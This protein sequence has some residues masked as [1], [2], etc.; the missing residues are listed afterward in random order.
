MYFGNHYNMLCYSVTS[1]LLSPCHGVPERV[2]DTS[3]V[4]APS[5]Y[6]QSPV[7]ERGPVITA[8]WRRVGHSSDSGGSSGD[9][10]DSSATSTDS[11]GDPPRVSVHTTPVIV[12]S[13]VISNVDYVSQDCEHGKYPWRSGSKSAMEHDDDSSSEE[14]KC[15]IEQYDEQSMS[16]TEVIKAQRHILQGNRVSYPWRTHYHDSDSDVSLSSL[17][18]TNMAAIF[19]SPTSHHGTEE[20]MKTINVAKTI[21]LHESLVSAL[22]LDGVAAPNTMEQLAMQQYPYVGYSPKELAESL[23]ISAIKSGL[24]NFNSTDPNMDIDLRGVPIENVQEMVEDLDRR[25]DRVAAQ[26]PALAHTQRHMNSKAIPVRS[27]E[28]YVA[29][30]NHENT[31]IFV[32]GPLISNET[33]YINTSQPMSA[34]AL[35]AIKQRLF[36]NPPLEEKTH[37][38]IYDL[39]SPITSPL[40]QPITQSEIISPRLHRKVHFAD[41]VEHSVI[42]I[43]PNWSR[44][45]LHRQE[46]RGIAADVFSVTAA[47]SEFQP[48]LTS[49]VITTMTLPDTKTSI[50]I[51]PIQTSPPLESHSVKHAIQLRSQSASSKITLVPTVPPIRPPV[52]KAHIMRTLSPTYSNAPSAQLANRV[53]VPPTLTRITYSPMYSDNLK[54][55]VL[56]SNLASQRRNSSPSNP[57]TRFIS[58]CRMI[59]SSTA[60]KYLGYSLPIPKMSPEL[61]FANRPQQGASPNIN[62]SIMHKRAD[63]IIPQRFE[64]MQREQPLSVQNMD[65]PSVA[66]TYSTPPTYEESM[67]NK[68]RQLLSEDAPSSVVGTPPPVQLR[69]LSPVYMNNFMDTLNSSQNVSLTSRNPPSPVYFTKPIATENQPAFAS[70]SLMSGTNSPV[71]IRD[72]S[73]PVPLTSM[74]YAPQSRPQGYIRQIS[75]HVTPVPTMIVPQHFPFPRQTTSPLANTAVNT[76]HHSI[77]QGNTRTKPTNINF[78]D[79]C[80]C[81]D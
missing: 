20:S 74:P 57:V 31:E 69:Q 3:I 46:Q 17:S 28:M 61:N 42:E 54:N 62:V 72:V 35:A 23:Q 71:V 44:R 36:G 52:Q 76:K 34:E 33:I 15:P 41:P 27:D 13:V 21:P 18:D 6:V 40:M 39:T 53:N 1:G 56:I 48:V 79:L 49:P 37:Q 50:V 26:E 2:G 51:S 55:N 78:I 14:K 80:L 60:S 70:P 64:I 29:T 9:S 24:D 58:P 25:L 38:R 81:L 10:S 67:R 5:S 68:S 77:A 32:D 65:A 47:A 75:R 30:T 73:S 19:S 11:G 22:A 59:P 66:I 45:R 12:P 43:P 8:S 7:R 4:A 63:Q 16:D